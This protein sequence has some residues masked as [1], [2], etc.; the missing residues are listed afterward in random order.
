MA[1]SRTPDIRVTPPPSPIKGQEVEKLN[2][3]I[4]KIAS[5]VNRSARHTEQIPDI[6]NKVEITREKVIALDTKMGAVT[7]RVAKVEDRV[8][9]GHACQIPDTIEALK[10]S[11]RDSSQKL[12]ITLQ[13]DA[14]QSG[15]I[16]ALKEDTVNILSDVADI[17]RAPQRLFYGL[18]GIV[19]TL[20]T[21]AAG[22][23]WFIAALSAE[24]EFERNR[25]TEQFQRIEQQLKGVARNTNPTPV[26]E[27]V[28]KLERTVRNSDGLEEEYNALCADMPF[29]EK[30]VFAKV[31]KRR[32]RRVPRSCL[33]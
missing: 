16:R 32:G 9:A 13:K 11:Q 5:A 17:K 7:E 21:G 27:Q 1:K 6:R 22:A 26:I 20:L 3:S 23:V 4:A 14:K 29:H 10:H 33:E 24:V 19:I 2:E 25:R 31:L 15:E 8:S 18:L 12:D 30:R 28:E